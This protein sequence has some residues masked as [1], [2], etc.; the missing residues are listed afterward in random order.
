MVRPT[1]AQRRTHSAAKALA[2]VSLPQ[3]PPA[4]R[5]PSPAQAREQYRQNALAATADNARLVEDRRRAKAEEA[6]REK[7]LDRQQIISEVRLA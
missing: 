1:A 6:Q 5:N 7:E 3:T 2:L 4:P